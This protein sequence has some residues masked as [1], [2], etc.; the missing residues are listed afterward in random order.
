MSNRVHV[1]WIEYAESRSVLEHAALHR[2]AS[3]PQVSI[4]YAG[5]GSVWFSW[6][7]V[8]RRRAEAPGANPRIKSGDGHDGN[9]SE[10]WAVG[11]RNR[12]DAVR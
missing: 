1:R 6:L 8:L 11:F 2:A 10:A 9:R 4:G 3:E 5:T 7:R 12:Q